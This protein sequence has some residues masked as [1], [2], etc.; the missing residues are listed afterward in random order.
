MKDVYLNKKTRDSA[1]F[2]QPFHWSLWFILVITM[3][4]IS[5][6]SF[7]I[8]YFSPYG[9]RRLENPDEEAKT[10]K[11]SNLNSDLTHSSLS[12]IS[13]WIAFDFRGPRR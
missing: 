2:L 5:A 7:I 8:D 3:F 9:H 13:S 6:I 12:R 4:V 1:G 11:N 10:S